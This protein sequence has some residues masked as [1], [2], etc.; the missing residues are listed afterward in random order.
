MDYWAFRLI[1]E[2]AGQHG[3]LDGTMRAVA[4]YGSLLFVVALLWL[5]GVEGGS[6]SVPDR[7]AVGR[8]LAAAGVALAFGQVVIWAL[9]RARPF[10]SH[11]VH[12]L[13]PPSADPSFP[14]DHALAAFAIAAAVLP[15]RRWLGFGLFGLGALLGVARVFVGTHYPLDVVGGAVIGGTIGTVV[16]WADA[17]LAPVVR[18]GT[19]W[20]DAA[21]RRGRR[22][23]DCRP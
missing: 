3:W 11:R 10:S 13:I 14:S 6:R 7:L 12:L 15:T 23:R 8:A 17:W 5:W 21:L 19:R 18:L 16:R 22:R 4:Q 2:W 20:S 1:N 9:P